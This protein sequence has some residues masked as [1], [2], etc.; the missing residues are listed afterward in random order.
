MVRIHL[1]EITHLGHACFKIKGKNAVLVTDPFDV[2][3]VGLKFPKTEADI[4]TISHH[5]DDHNKA[6][7]VGADPFVVDGPGEYEIRGVGIFG[8]ST[9][10]DEKE[11]SLR[12]Q[13]TIYQ[14]NLD[15]ATL[16]HLGD[17]GEKLKDEVLDD[18]PDIDILFIP[19]GGVYTLDAE[20]AV[21]VVNQIEPKVVIPM[22]YQVEGL[23]PESFRELSPVDKFLKEIDRE[24]Q[25]LSKLLITK[26]KLPEERQVI[27]FE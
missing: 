24:P 16:L 4:V 6:E 3:K 25:K 2:K 17:L 10:H 14:I 27:V 9:S 20:K 18:L 7:L 19:V 12:G 23:N 22:H 13:N 15:G 1:M 8:F 11:G 5:H 21:E 26:D